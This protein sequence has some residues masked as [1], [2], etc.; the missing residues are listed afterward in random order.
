MMRMLL[1]NELDLAFLSY[2]ATAESL[3]T[4]LIIKEELVLL[5]PEKAGKVRV[6]DLVASCDLPLIVQRQAC[7]YTER[8]FILSQG[9]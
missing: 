5:G 2:P 4:E 7:S 1:E 8:F 3:R 9:E 6:N